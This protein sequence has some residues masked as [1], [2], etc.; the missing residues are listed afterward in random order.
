MSYVRVSILGVAPG[1]EVW[2]INPT[3][4]PTFEFGTTVD[5]SAL[6]AAC[7]AIAE[8]N[9]GS[10]LL[11]F[12]SSQ[13]GITGARLE[14]RD[15][16]TDG[17]MAIS[18]RQRGIPKYGTGA[19]LRGAQTAL[20]VS[21][22]TDTPGGSGRGRLYWPAVATPVNTTLRFDSSYTGSA[23]N[24]IAVYLHAMESALATA[25]PTIGFDLAVRSKTTKTTPHVN[26]IQIGNVPDTQRRRRDKMIEDYVS[27][28]F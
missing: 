23:L 10:D 16:A 5:Q 25:F 21:L 7:L 3:I 22:R 24:Q 27:A 12:L 4:D 8:L 13:L 19:P 9:P 1:N 15:D 6:D 14:V 20:V 2:S 18:V 11:G 17:L 26:K 28:A